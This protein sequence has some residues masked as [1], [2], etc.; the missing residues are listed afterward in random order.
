MQL[1][2]EKYIAPEVLSLDIRVEGVI[3]TLSGTG[4]TE[5][6]ETQVDWGEIGGWS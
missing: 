4:A 2:R 1:I 3:L 6:I 5:N